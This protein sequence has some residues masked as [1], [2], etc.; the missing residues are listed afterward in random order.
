MKNILKILTGLLII[1]QLSSCSE[2]NG[3]SKRE[4]KADML[5]EAP[6]GHAQV[7]HSPDGDL[8]SQYTNFMIVFSVAKAD[9]FDGNYIISNGGYAFS[10][11]IGKWKFNDALDQIILDSG[12]PMDIQLDA[13][14][15]QLDFV[16]TSA[17][18]KMIGLSG[19][20]VFDLQPL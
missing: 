7:T 5:T 2:D 18:G 4:V 9:G 1:L 3:K 14:Y 15:L 19:H 6:W 16:T 10:E 17:G 11:T 13:D 8:S 12:K 20:F